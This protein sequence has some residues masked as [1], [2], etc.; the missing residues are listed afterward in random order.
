MTNTLFNDMLKAV[1]A[2]PSGTTSMDGNGVE[3]EVVELTRGFS[4]SVAL[5][6]PICCHI[7]V[8][9]NLIHFL[10]DGL[11]YGP[12]LCILNGLSGSF[13]YTI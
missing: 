9:L 2:F 5:E 13:Q 3:L 1:I 8:T 11:K 7:T 6:Y 4:R 10:I 12:K